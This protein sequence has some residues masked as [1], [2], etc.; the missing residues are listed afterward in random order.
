MNDFCPRNHPDGE[1]RSQGQPPGECE[2]VT[3][4]LVASGSNALQRYSLISK[5][6]R[7]AIFSYLLNEG[8]CVV[9]KDTKLPTNPHIFV[10]KTVGEGSVQKP[11]PN[12][13]VMM[14][15]RSLESMGHVIHYYNWQH[16][17]YTLT[18]EGIEYLRR[19]LGVPA[20]VQPAT[21]AA[22]PRAMGGRP[23]G[24]K[25]WTRGYP[26]RPTAEA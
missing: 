10:E 15:M 7:K 24:D 25:P 23:G 2:S 4:V 12:L 5:E 11:I 21:R 17:Y 1:R 22:P 14:A 8:V 16:H 3:M 26:S 20:C 19:Y 13:H 18:P 6:N 9:K